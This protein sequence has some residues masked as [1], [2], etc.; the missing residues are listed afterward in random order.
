MFITH[1]RALV[2]NA[3]KEALTNQHHPLLGD[4]KVWVGMDYPNAKVNY[5]GVWVTF[6]PNGPIQIAGVSHVEYRGDDEIRK[7]TRWRFSGTISATVVALSGHER[8]DLLDEVIRLV[9]F[10]SEHPQTSI[11]R[12]RLENNNLIALNVQY[13]QMNIVGDTEGPGTPWGS[14]DMVFEATTTMLCEGEFVSDLTSDKILVPLEDIIVYDYAEPVEVMP[15]A[16]PD[17]PGWI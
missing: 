14:D 16:G 4:K 13:D 12:S 1:A 5:P 8:D 6:K 15:P 2:A 10:G 9:A 7:G 11:L 3:F 17:N